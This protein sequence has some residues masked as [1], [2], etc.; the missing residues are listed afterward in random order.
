MAHGR[1]TAFPSSGNYPEESGLTKR[2]LI[3][4]MVMQGFIAADDHQHVA[5]YKGE[6]NNTFAKAAVRLADELLVEL[7]KTQEK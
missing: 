6:D 3:A 1:D 2:E 7:K 4:A 5:C